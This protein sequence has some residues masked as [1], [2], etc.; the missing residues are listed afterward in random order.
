MKMR[1]A[2]NKNEK[3]MAPEVNRTFDIAD[4]ERNMDELEDL[5]LE[6]ED[7][8][9]EISEERE[10]PEPKAENVE[11]KNLLICN[12]C[13]WSTSHSTSHLKEHMDRVHE[14][15]KYPCDLCAYKANKQQNLKDHKACVHKID[16]YYRCLLCV[17]C[18]NHSKLWR[19]H[20]KSKHPNFKEEDI[21][22]FTP[23]MK[24]IN[25]RRYLR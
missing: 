15:V 23:P 25:G 11:S 19:K 1:N 10:E 21:F 14:G 13:S 6:L 24:K 22:E 16:P 4:M 8:E 18:T 2:E 3:A 20:A 12:I 9:L 7:E 17:F 5:E